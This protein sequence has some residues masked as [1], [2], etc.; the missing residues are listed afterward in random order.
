VGS[1]REKWAKAEF[2]QPSVQYPLGAGALSAPL[3]HETKGLGPDLRQ[4]ELVPVHTLLIHLTSASLSVLLPLPFVLVRCRGC[5]EVQEPDVDPI[6][7]QGGVAT[8]EVVVVP[9]PIRWVEIQEFQQL[10]CVGAIPQHGKTIL[11]AMN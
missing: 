1:P 5:G 10:G 9:A 4:D 3:C 6:V 2:I 7:R 11:S 8:P